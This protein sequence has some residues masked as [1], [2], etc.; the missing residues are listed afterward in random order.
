MRRRSIVVVSCH[1][2]LRSTFTTEGSPYSITE[3]GV[4]E[5]IPVLGSQPAID[6]SHKPGGRLPLLSSRPAVTSFTA[7]WTEAQWVWT[8]CLRLLPDS[9]ATRVAVYLCHYN[10][11][12]HLCVL[13]TSTSYSAIIRHTCCSTYARVDKIKEAPAL[14]GIHNSYYIA[15]TARRRNDTLNCLLFCDKTRR[16]SGCGNSIGYIKTLWIT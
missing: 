3:R 4:P 2:I 12:L 13:Q 11:H 14:P 15:R 6:V 9:V 7:W 10:K 16:P 5:L 1:L 8:V